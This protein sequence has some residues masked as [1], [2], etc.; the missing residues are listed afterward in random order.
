MKRSE[1][2]P[3]ASSLLAN[4]CFILDLL[5]VLTRLSAFLSSLFVVSEMTQNCARQS[6]LAVRLGA[7]QL[8]TVDVQCEYEL[9]AGIS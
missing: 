2:E 4:D 6:L 3:L 1:T 8:Q 5:N 7:A 9:H